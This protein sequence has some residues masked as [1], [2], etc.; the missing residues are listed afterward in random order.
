MSSTISLNRVKLNQSVKYAL[1]RGKTMGINY[2]VGNTQDDI[3]NGE[4]KDDDNSVYSDFHI[5]LYL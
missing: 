3:A 4:D 1:N 2:L 5:L